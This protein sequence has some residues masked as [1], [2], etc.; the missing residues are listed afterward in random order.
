M[1]IDPSLFD[2]PVTVEEWDKKISKK[3]VKGSMV[4]GF[5]F[6]DNAAYYERSAIAF[7]SSDPYMP[8]DS[9]KLGEV[10]KLKAAA[11]TMREYKTLE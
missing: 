1:V 8:H 7:S 5:P 3:T 6:P 2:R 11:E 10:D 4:T 9:L